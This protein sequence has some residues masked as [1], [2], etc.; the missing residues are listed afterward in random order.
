[1]IKKFL[2][3]SF[4]ALVLAF[5]GSA[6][7][8]VIDLVDVGLNI[9][10]DVSV[11]TLGDPIPAEADFSLFDFFTG[12][13]SIA[14]EITGAGAY[15][16]D[17]FVDLEIDQAINTFFNEFGTSTGSPGTDQSWEID[18]PGFLFGDIF[19]NFLISALDNTNAVPSGLDDDVSMALGW[20]FTLGMDETATITFF[21]SD[22]LDAPGF[23]L[24][25]TDPASDASIYFWSTLEIDDDGEVP[26]PEPGTLWLLGA[27]LMALG[28]SRRR[29]TKH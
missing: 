28:L 27:G 10:G 14:V 17:L 24:T 25:Q 11:P 2:L 22:F 19:D 3:S 7:A 20:D 26:V 16:V 29:I 15:N 1:M 4:G 13:G 8:A 5:S 23:F 12:L 6:Q 18:E 9:D 21:L